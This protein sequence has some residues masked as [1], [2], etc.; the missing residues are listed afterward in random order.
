MPYKD[1]DPA[2]LWYTK[3]F[4]SETQ[5]LSMEDRGKLMTLRAAFH[6]HGRLNKKQVDILI[7]DVSTELIAMIQI[8]SKGM[9][10]C[11]RVEHEAKKRKEFKARKS[12]DGQKGNKVKA[13]MKERKITKEE[14]R[15]ILEKNGEVFGKSKHSMLSNISQGEAPSVSQ[16]GRNKANAFG[17]ENGIVDELKRID[18]IIEKQSYQLELTKEEKEL[19]E[20]HNLN[21]TGQFD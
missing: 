18:E 1:K 11:E 5:F 12:A 10:Y 8:D 4:L 14:A 6:Q 9:H 3:D 17:N 13:I 16:S 20:K 2:I 7:G 15:K 21:Y 19:L